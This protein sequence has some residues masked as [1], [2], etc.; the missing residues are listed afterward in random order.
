M[1]KSEEDRKL[2]ELSASLLSECSE[3]KLINYRTTFKELGLYDEFKEIEEE[4]IKIKE[5]SSEDKGV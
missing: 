1:N 4:A 2:R 3:E 5:Q